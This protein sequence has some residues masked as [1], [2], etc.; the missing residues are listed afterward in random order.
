M[1]NV[2]NPPP[3]TTRH[4]PSFNIFY[5]KAKVLRYFIS[6]K[7]V[8]RAF[9]SGPLKIW[10]SLPLHDIKVHFVVHQF[11][12]WNLPPETLSVVQMKLSDADNW[13]HPTRLF[14][15]IPQSYVCICLRRCF[16][17]AFE[18]G[19]CLH[20]LGVHKCSVMY[21][22]CFIWML[23]SPK[24]YGT[25]PYLL[26]LWTAVG[27]QTENPSLPYFTL[28]TTF[29]QQNVDVILNDIWNVLSCSYLFTRLKI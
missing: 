4:P 7:E 6:W 19:I 25:D 23:K 20:S 22:D 12:L 14:Q 21:L 13:W 8:S 1:L 24:F 9:N 5:T 16:L 11:P 15:K 29:C 27:F 17:F 26:N 3:P 28:L 2:D 10:I 18:R